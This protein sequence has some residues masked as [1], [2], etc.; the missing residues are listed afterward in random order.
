VSAPVRRAP[1]RPARTASRS[2]PRRRPTP[3]PL[4]RRRWGLVVTAGALGLLLSAAG[5]I[6]LN[7]VP[8]LAPPGLRARLSRYLWYNWAATSAH[9][10]SLAACDQLVP[11]ANGRVAR[12]ASPA[13]SP[14][15]AGPAFPEL[16]QRGFPGLPPDQLFALSHETIQNLG[17][18][19]VANVDPASRILQCTYT[20]R[21]LRLVDD[22]KI[23]VLPDSEIALCSRSRHFLPD[24]GSNL[25]HIQEFYAALGQP[26][27]HAYASHAQI[28]QQRLRASGWR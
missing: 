10:A 7:N 2:S 6:A 27:E 4:P 23:V 25:G 15:D 11:R 5:A 3:R 17:G 26:I 20:S 8:L 12:T 14:A 28:L 1:R 24:F 18:W 21:L 9:G 13:H 19:R 16:I 22:I